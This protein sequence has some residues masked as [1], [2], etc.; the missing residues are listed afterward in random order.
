MNDDLNHE[1]KARFDRELAGLRTP[2]TWSLRKRRSSPLRAAVTVAIV[3][4]LLVGATAGGLAL[5]AAR[6]SQSAAPSAPTPT[7][8]P[9]AS[10]SPTRSAPG[11]PTPT[12][13]PSPTSTLTPAERVTITA[14]GTL[15]GDV[16][17]VV[18]RTS[19]ALPGSDR[20]G[21]YE[22]V[23]VPLAGGDPR[24][25]VV[26]ELTG[27]RG[28]TAAPVPTAR[29]QVSPDG[30][31]FA[32]ASESH[33]IVVVDLETGTARQI[34]KDPDY[35]DD[36]P[37]WSEDGRKL[38]FR[39]ARGGSDGGIWTMNADGTEPRRAIIGDPLRASSGEPVFDWTPD[40]E[41]VCYWELIDQYRCV[42]TADAS[43]FTVVG[44]VNG[45]APADWRTRSPRLVSASSQRGAGTAILAAEE[46]RSGTPPRTIATGPASEV[47][48]LSP[49][50]H[51]TADEVAYV[52]VRS[53]GGARPG[54]SI[55][56]NVAPL[57][58]SPRPLMTQGAPREPEWSPGGEEVLFLGGESNTSP[59][60]IGLFAARSDGGTVRTVWL[61]S[62]L[63]S[64]ATRRY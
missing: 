59:V 39:R 10:P 36:E 8:A 57:T 41:V 6:E 64:L 63:V 26:W 38:A 33:H 35:F 42:H 60:N 9:S 17:W 2:A 46:P 22:L 12:P 49:R 23:L 28:G 5:R 54:P 53:S 25:A 50:W 19:V 15:R 45:Q 14:T 37:V 3:A 56:L 34:T 1:L 55:R 32:F 40:G 20:P 30:R 58:G 43:L 62:D 7:I 61:A 52:E 13:A 21:R 29:Q 4:A 48:Y 31:R 44:N 27:S 18:R 11:S 51:P 16:A 24:V 47:E